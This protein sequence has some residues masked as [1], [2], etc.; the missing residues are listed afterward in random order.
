MILGAGRRKRAG[1]RA[2][3]NTVRRISAGRGRERRAGGIGGILPPD[4]ETGATR[5]LAADRDPL[6]DLARR[7]PMSGSDVAGSINNPSISKYPRQPPIRD[8]SCENRC[9]ILIPDRRAGG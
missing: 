7:W 9:E 2:M 4:P 8:R 3:A 5:R 6:L 1:S